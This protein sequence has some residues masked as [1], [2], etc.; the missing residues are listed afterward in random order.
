[1]LL[2]LH[3]GDSLGATLEFCSPQAKENW[4]RDIIG[5]GHF[6]WKPGDATDD[7]DLALTILE[8]LEGNSFN[9]KLVLIN[10]SLA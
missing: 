7:T 8:S 5:G 10:D 1:M 2:G 9:Q 3:C 6:R 4:Q